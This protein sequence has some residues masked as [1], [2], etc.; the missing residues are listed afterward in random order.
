MSRPSKCPQCGSKNVYKEQ[1]LGIKTGDWVCGDCGEV[2]L[3]NGVPIG[4]VLP[5]H[6]E[7]KDKPQ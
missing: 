4:T 7:D 2:G 5:E 6:K 3:L 1:V